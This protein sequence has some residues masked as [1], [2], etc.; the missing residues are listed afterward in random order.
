MAFSALRLAVPALLL[1]LS[2]ASCLSIG[3]GRDTTSTTVV[4]PTTEQQ[5]MDLKKGLD[6]GAVSKEEYETLRQR[7]ISPR[8]DK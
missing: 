1:L 3:G 4:Q 6:T 7:I 5:L 2:A 8:S